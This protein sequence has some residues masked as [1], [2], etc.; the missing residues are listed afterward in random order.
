MTLNDFPYHALSVTTCAVSLC[1]LS[2]QVVGGVRQ[3]GVIL[4]LKSINSTEPP[5]LSGRSD[6]S[7]AM[8]TKTDAQLAQELEE[9]RRVWSIV[10]VLL[11]VVLI[12]P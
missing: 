7:S 3:E 10:L 2:L 12:D 4:R 1:L 11:M 9:F 5:P 6:L 8:S